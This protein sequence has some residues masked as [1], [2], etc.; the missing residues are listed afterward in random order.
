LARKGSQ[1]MSEEKPS[2]P[3][4]D[5]WHAHRTGLKGNSNPHHEER[6]P[7]SHN[8]WQAGFS[9][10][11]SAVKHELKPEWDHEFGL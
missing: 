10:R 3:F 5:G 7:Y 1:Q 8:Q 11:H 2:A 4:L 9:A 6:Q